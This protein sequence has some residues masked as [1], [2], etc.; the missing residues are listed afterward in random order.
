MISVS[1]GLVVPGGAPLDLIHRKVDEVKNLFYR[2]IEMQLDLPFRKS[3]AP[4][5]EIQEQFCPWLFQAAASSYQFAV[6]IQKPAQFK[7]FPSK[8]PKIEEVTGK[9][10]EVL[11][12]SAKESH[13][14]LI[15]IIP[16]K[17]YR[18]S[19][20]KLT[21]NLAP[22][23]KSF[24]KLEIKSAIDKESLPIIFMPESRKA[25]NK[26]LRDTK[27]N[28]IRILNIQKSSFQGFYVHFIW[29]KTGLKLTYLKNLMRLEF[30]KLEI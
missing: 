1:G 20:L 30:I 22:T 5:S 24:E 21:R 11:E 14:E 4:K 2:I 7:M 10:F 13:D 17:D 25:L 15:K 27:K 16:N 12:A 3:G 8:Q 26:T 6:R 23:G 18:D 19:F 28:L 29:I 9:F